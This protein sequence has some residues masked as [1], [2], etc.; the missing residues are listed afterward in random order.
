VGINNA[1]S[2]FRI[3][4]PINPGNSGGPILD[5]HGI[6]VGIAVAV[7][8]QERLEGIAF[9]IKINVAF[10]MLQQLSVDLKETEDTPISADEIFKRF[11][12]DVVYI[13]IQ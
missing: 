9:G 3:T 10:P 11:G 8:R 12:Q 2:Q 4:A 6:V 7:I 13:R 1:Q 5:D